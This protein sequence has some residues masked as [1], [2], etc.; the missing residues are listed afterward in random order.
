MVYLIIGLS[1]VVI[2]I[3][4]ILWLNQLK[5][6]QVK[7]INAIQLG[8][9]LRLFER[10]ANAEYDNPSF[11]AAAVTNELLC[12]KPESP[13]SKEYLRDNPELI[14][15]EANAIYYD[16][17]IC[18]AA[19]RY[20]DIKGVLECMRPNN[21]DMMVNLL[22]IGKKFE[23][24]GY[25]INRKHVIYHSFI[26]PFFFYLYARHFFGRSPMKESIHY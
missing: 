13:E 22:L 16:K 23:D 15:Q 9:C 8:I 26:W 3:L 5:R 14:R 21:E 19:S 20:I 12:G 25:N 11:L 7:G 10:Y 18:K 2:Y 1:I 6:W 4:F 17:E 24:L